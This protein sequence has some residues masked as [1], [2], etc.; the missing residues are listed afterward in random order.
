MPGKIQLLKRSSV[1]LTVI[2]CIPCS[3]IQI[4]VVV[5]APLHN[6]HSSEFT[7]SKMLV[8]HAYKISYNV[9]FK[10]KKQ[11]RLINYKIRIGRNIPEDSDPIFKKQAAPSL[12]YAGSR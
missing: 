7:R 8:Q 12:M 2:C 1:G 6:L 4:V 10:Y 9:K 11:I 5:V 3:P